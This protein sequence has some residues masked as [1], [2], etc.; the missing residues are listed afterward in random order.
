[1]SSSSSATTAIGA[2]GGQRQ[3]SLLELPRGVG[4]GGLVAGT[5]G[6]CGRG[7]SCRRPRCSRWGATVPPW[8]S[9]IAADDQPGPSPVPGTAGAPCVRRAEEALEEAGAC[10]SAGIAHPGVR[11]R[12]HAV[13]ALEPHRDRAMVGGELDRVREKV[14]EDLAEAH[15]VSRDERG[16]PLASS[17]IAIDLRVAAGS[18]RS[19]L[20]RTISSSSTDVALERRRPRLGALEEQEVVDE[21]RQPLGVPLHDRQELHGLLAERRDVVLEQ[22]CVPLDRREWRPQARGRRSR[23]TPPWPAR[24]P[25][26]PPSRAARRSGP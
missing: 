7:A 8:A 25:A 4:A 5:G 21:P 1:M 17:P 6:E 11:D 23:R 3:H 14:V 13:R 10:S 16:A 18:T 22:L 24:Q 15:R 12:A 2:G 9:A 26:P 19:M 20:C